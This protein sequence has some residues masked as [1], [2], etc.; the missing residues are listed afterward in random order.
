VAIHN[1][2]VGM[3]CGLALGAAFGAAFNKRKEDSN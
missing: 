1:L 3:A 2:V